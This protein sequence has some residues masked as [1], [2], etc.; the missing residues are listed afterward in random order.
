MQL[1]VAS[2][3]LPAFVIGLG[4]VFVAPLDGDA[5]EVFRTLRMWAWCAALMSMVV[6]MMLLTLQGH[7]TPWQTTIHVALLTIVLFAHATIST[8]VNA[9]DPTRAIARGV[10]RS[11]IILCS[12]GWTIEMRREKV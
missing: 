7:R 4:V 1:F 5:L 2:V 8:L 12:L 6:T 3:A 10:F 9:P 11:A